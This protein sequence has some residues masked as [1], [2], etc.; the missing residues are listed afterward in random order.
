MIFSELNFLLIFFPIYCVFC[1]YTIINRSINFRIV[2]WILFGFSI[3]FHSQTNVNHTLLL[4]VVLT[5]SYYFSELRFNKEILFFFS[6]IYVLSFLFVF[7]Y[8]EFFAENL[9]P[10]L[11][12]LA[13]PLALPLGISFYSFQIISF[14]RDKLIGDDTSGGFDFI[15]FAAYVAF[16]PQLVAGPIVRAADMAREFRLW[17]RLSIRIRWWRF[18]HGMFIFSL[19]LASKVLLADRFAPIANR[20]FDNPDL[21]KVGAVDAYV[22]INAYS[23]QIFFDFSG[24]SAMAIGL[25]LLA[26]IRLPSNFDTPYRAASIVEFWQR[27]HITLSR[28]LRDFIYIPLGGNRKGNIRRNINLLA[29]MLLGGLWHGA[30]WTFIFW[31]ALHGTYLL[32]AHLVGPLRSV[33]RAIKIIVT[34]HLVIFAW[35]FFRAENFQTALS[36]VKALDLTNGVGLPVRFADED[37]YLML[38]GMLIVFILPS[39][40][41]VVAS[42]RIFYGYY[43]KLPH[44]PARG[45][46]TYVPNFWWSIFTFGLMVFSIWSVRDDSPF[47]YF[48]F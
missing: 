42:Q 22:G 26:G 18:H 41:I 23:F 24:Y 25:G 31:G 17:P 38:A 12:F 35:I 15:G 20:L 45:F 44:K 14:L 19:G 8:H 33:P 2:L 46:F 13:A 43:E 29:T 27:W 36:I 16:F 11:P 7:K 1:I 47:I 37:V 21:D 3:L 32:A 28:F 39:E 4:L 48:Q 6:V 30:G 40:R 5:T 9:F 10:I 34:Y